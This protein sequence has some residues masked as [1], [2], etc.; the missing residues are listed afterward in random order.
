MGQPFDQI[1][2]TIYRDSD[3]L[4]LELLGDEAGVISQ[5]GLTR[6]ALVFIECGEFHLVSAPPMIS[7]GYVST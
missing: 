7:R 1:S 6:P 2:L 5:G 3:S 4:D